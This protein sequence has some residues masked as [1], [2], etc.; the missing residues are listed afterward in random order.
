MGDNKAIEIWWKQAVFYHIYPRSFYDADNNGIGDIEGIIQKMDYLNDGKGGGLGVDAIW[1]SPFFKSP[2]ADFGYDVSDYCDIDPIFGTLTD[3]DRLVAEA[4]K[5]RIKVVIDLVLN[6]TSDQHSWFQGSSQSKTGEKADW[7]IWEDPAKDG[8]PPNNWLSIFGGPGWTYHANRKQYYFHNF[9][10]EQPDLNWY[11]PEVR[12][13]LKKVVRFWIDRGTDGFRLDTA[14][15]YAHDRNLRD[16]PLSKDRGRSVEDTDFNPYYHYDTVYSKDRP[17]NMEF[18][19][20]LRTLFDFCQ[21]FISVC[22]IGGVL[23]LEKVIGAAAEHVRGKDRLHMAYTFSL[24][25]ENADIKYIENVISITESLMKEGWP[26]WS[27][28]NHDITRIKTRYGCTG[29]Q[30]GLQQAFLLLLLSMRGTPV[31]YYGDEID[32]DDADI[33]KED[34]QDPYGIRFWPEFKGRDGCRTPFAWDK[35]KPNQG[36]NAGHKPWLPSESRSDLKKSLENSQSTYYVIREMIGLRKNLKPLSVGTYRQILCGNHSL[37][38]ER[39][40]ENQTILVAVNTGEKE[41][42]INLPNNCRITKDIALKHFARN[43]STV[44]GV[45][46]LPAMGF[47]LG[48]E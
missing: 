8:G 16:N 37:V 6:H 36:F 30:E 35:N 21:I 46:N 42:S 38:F 2:M 28:G 40:Y 14:N 13:A 47:Y 22:E 5:R 10:K 41:E 1:V 44:K 15:F 7:Y 12:E 39:K 24:L 17:E 19:S 20:F 45:L 18:I 26:C 29:D 3:Y 48:E 4:H 32:M 34:L 31:L 11:N 33:S 23:G 27:L 9:L 43:G 25:N